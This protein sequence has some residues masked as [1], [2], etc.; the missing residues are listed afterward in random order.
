MEET[1]VMRILVSGS[2]VVVEGRGPK[3]GGV[4]CVTV[5]VVVG[6]NVPPGRVM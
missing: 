5:V 3:V 1:E 6:A 4:S 2:V